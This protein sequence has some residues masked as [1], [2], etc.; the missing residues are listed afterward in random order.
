MIGIGVINGLKRRF[1]LV[2]QLVAEITVVVIN[3]AIN[4]CKN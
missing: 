2:V 3:N 1:E 4:V